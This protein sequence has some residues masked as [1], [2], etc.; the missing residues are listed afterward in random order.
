MSNLDLSIVIPID[1]NRRSWDI[2]KRIKN[3]V[4]IFAHSNIQI[5]LGCHNEPKFWVSC[6]QKLIT[7]YNNFKLCLVS[8]QK[9]SLAK[10]RNI[11]LNQVQTRYVLFLDVDIYPDIEIIQQAYK[12]TINKPNTLAMFPC[13]YLSKMGSKK[14][15]TKPTTEFIKNYYDFRRDLI[16]HLAFPSSIILTDLASVQAINGFDEAYIGHGYEDFDFMLRLFKYKGLIEY[17][18]D[19]LVDEPYLAPLMSIGFRA[20]L[21]KS[22]LEILLSPYYFLHIFHK[23]NKQE[24]Y[25]RLRQINQNYFNSKFHIMININH[26]LDKL[27]LLQTFFMLLKDKKESPKY[28]VLWAEIEGYKFRIN[29]Y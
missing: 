23:K 4:R 5:I 7:P 3:Y 22:C 25:Y 1:L 2:Y 9:S 28:A 16:Q 29:S 12:Y 10:L 14:I 18:N 20:L 6:V 13:L 8:T 11:A 27:A 15:Y 24:S 17:T 26:E 21:A 19:I